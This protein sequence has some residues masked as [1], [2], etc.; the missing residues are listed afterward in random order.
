LWKKF[1]CWNKKEG[2]CKWKKYYNIFYKSRNVFCL[3]RPN[4]YS[5][6]IALF[7]RCYYIGLK[8][9]QS[10]S[11]AIFVRPGVNFINIKSANFTYEWHFGSFFFSYVYVK[12][13]AETTFV[14]KIRTYNIDEIDGRL[15]K[16]W[17]NGF[18]YAFTADVLRLPLTLRR[19]KNAFKT[20]TRYIFKQKY[21]RW[22]DLA[23]Y[24]VSIS[25]KYLQCWPLKVFPLS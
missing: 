9:W 14:W 7:G 24:S 19:F 15:V 16:S 5:F 6:K 2:I 21:L 18:L 3:L 20:F 12:K 13:A 1:P 25:A 23:D 4:V 17:W 22:Y 11:E 10:D 8:N